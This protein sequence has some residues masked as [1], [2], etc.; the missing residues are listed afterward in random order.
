MARTYKKSPLSTPV[1]NRKKQVRRR[2]WRHTDTPTKARILGTKNYLTEN[3]VR[4]TNLSIY[5][6]FNVYRRTGQRILKAGTVRRHHNDP[7]AGGEKRGRHRLLDDEAIDKIEKLLWEQGFEARRLPW[8]ALPDAAGVEFPGRMPPSGKTVRRALGHRDYR[9]CIACVKSWVAE[10]SALTRVV[11]AKEQLMAHKFDYECYWSRIR[12]SDETHFR[13]GPEGRIMVVRKPGER[14][15][16]D[17]IHHRAEPDGDDNVCL[18]AWAAVG[19]GFKSEL[20]W[21]DV[22]NSNGS[23]TLKT[24]LEQILQP[25]VGRWLERGDDFILEEDGA[26]GHG[27]KSTNNIV[28]QWKQRVGLK[29]FRN[30][31]NSPDLAP[32]EN[33]W[34]APKGQVRQHAIWN[35][36]ALKEYAE[37][38]WAGLKQ[39]TIDDWVIS[40]PSR[41]RDVVHLKGQLSAF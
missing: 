28:A 34:R 6:Q 19:Y 4:H 9:K 40:L 29:H 23:M 27:Y 41:L 5:K 14:Y 13:F 38:G 25:V 15:C 30:C 8:A 11:W 10:G 33:A 32:I 20:V 18:S 39:K 36:E 17:C 37:L 26:S 21:Y 7:F 1:S 16:P 35:P 12:Y 31:P 24:Y 22:G 2:T 3:H